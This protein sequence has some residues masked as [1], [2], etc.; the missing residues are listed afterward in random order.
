MHVYRKQSSCLAVG[1]KSV[2]NI[3]NVTV[4]SPLH[5]VPGGPKK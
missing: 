1:G 2:V 3:Q 5:N 4:V